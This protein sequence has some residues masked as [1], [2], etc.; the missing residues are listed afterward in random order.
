MH[1]FCIRADNNRPNPQSSPNSYPASWAFDC[2]AGPTGFLWIADQTHTFVTGFLS[3]LNM[4][5]PQLA[6]PGQPSLSSAT[7]VQPVN[8]FK[9]SLALSAARGCLHWIQHPGAGIN[10]RLLKSYSPLSKARVQLS[11]QQK[12]TV[13][14]VFIQSEKYKVFSD[15]QLL[16]KFSQ[17]SIC[18]VTII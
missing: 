4:Q 18:W 11:T 5:K 6:H 2:L 8:H 16:R 13:Q 3:H 7:T 15:I 17:K 1:Q 14:F 12:R 9:F 10:K